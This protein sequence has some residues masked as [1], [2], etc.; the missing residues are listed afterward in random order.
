[1][2]RLIMILALVVQTFL[3]THAQVKARVEIPWKEDVHSYLVIPM[4]EEGMLLA[5]ISDKSSDGRRTLRLSH[6]DT[7][8]RLVKSDSTQLDRSLD[9]EEYL[10]DEGRCLVVLREMGRVLLGPR[11][12]IGDDIAIV[13]YTPSTRKMGVVNGKYPE[14]ASMGILSVGD[15]IMAFNS[16]KRYFGYIGMVDLTTGEGQVLDPGLRGGRRKECYILRTTVVGD[17]VL[18]LVRTKKGTH[19][20]RFDRQGGRKSCVNLTPDITQRLLTA[21]FSEKDGSLLVT[22]TFTNHKKK[23]YDQGIYFA[24]I[25]GDRLAFIRFYNF[26]DLQHFTE[27]MSSKGQKKVERRKERAERKGKEL[28][29][30]KLV[31]SHGLMEQGGAYYYVGEA[32]FPTYITT[33]TGFSTVTVFDGYKYTHAVLVKFDADGNLL[34]DNCFPMDPTFKPKRVIHFVAAGFDGRN[35][36]ALYPDRRLLVSKLFSDTDGAVVQDKQKEVMGTGD[37]DEDVKKAKDTETV[38]WHGD[39]FL[40]HGT[41]IVKNNATGERRKVIFINKYTIE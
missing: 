14:N 29:V 35:V 40:V 27:Y 32:Y 23:T 17:E 21:S 19:L 3:A 30:N 20:V 33:S 9:F 2:R 25:D 13:T 7:D 1:M 41:Q 24:R 5:T 10:Y 38:Y 26:L 12:V 8:L 18:S 36:N 28:V 15:G 16:V 39:N 37:E 22:G 4:G 31:T 11:K 6:Y 34:W